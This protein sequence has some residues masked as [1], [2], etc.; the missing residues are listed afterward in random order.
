VLKEKTKEVF[1]PES[2]SGKKYLQAAAE[3]LIS[4][5]KMSIKPS[6]EPP[7]LFFD[8]RNQL[9]AFHLAEA[10]RAFGLNA[11]A[12]SL[13]QQDVSGL[14]NQWEKGQWI[15]VM[16]LTLTDAMTDRPEEK[17][18]LGIYAYYL[19]QF[20][21]V[22]DNRVRWKENSF[23][24]EQQTSYVT[25]LLNNITDGQ[26]ITNESNKL[27]FGLGELTSK[28][29]KDIA[30]FINKHRLEKSQFKIPEMQP[31]P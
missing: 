6:D 2:E 18:I 15:A 13:T 27:V 25:R 11:E 28:I 24:T 19:E 17:T 4:G 26:L 23:L 30:E 12:R 5:T 14:K 21:N 7:Q 16:P 29:E 31:A 8:A 9:H 10:L 22:S 3:R 1:G 20:L